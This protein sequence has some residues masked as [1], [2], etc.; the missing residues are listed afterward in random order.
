[1]IEGAYIEITPIIRVPI[2]TSSVVIPAKETY[3]ETRY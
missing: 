2:T 3:E 1:M